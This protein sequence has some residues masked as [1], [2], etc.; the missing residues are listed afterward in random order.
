MITGFLHYCTLLLPEFLLF[1]TMPISIETVMPVRTANIICLMVAFTIHAFES[2]RIW[3]PCFGSHLVYFLVFYATPC[4]FSV[5]FCR[6][7]SIALGAFR[8]M[9]MTVECCM[10]PFPTVLTLWNAQVYICS[11]NSSYKMS[12]MFFAKEL[13]WESQISTQM[14]IMSDLGDTLITCSFKAN[15]MSLN[16]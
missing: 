7:S 15:M 8:D 6:V 16:K 14:T 1:P 12:N 2:V 10:A 5:V 11:S 13:L 3:L 4:S 9:R